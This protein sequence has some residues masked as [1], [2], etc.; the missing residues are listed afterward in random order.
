M[1][2]VFRVLVACVFA[3]VIA[4]DLFTSNAW[5]LGDFSKTCRDA[6]VSGSTLRASCEKANGGFTPTSIDLN[7][8]IGN[9]D[10]SLSWNDK[11]FIETCRG[12]ALKS[13]STL[14]AECKKRN[15]DFVGTSINLDDHIANIDGNLR[16]E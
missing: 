16:Y 8:Y 5:A 10:G 1:N 3:V 11:N 12:T 13:G 4:F 14:T 9:I 7:P 6:S 15:Q 2:R